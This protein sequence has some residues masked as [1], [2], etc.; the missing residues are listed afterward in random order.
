MRRFA[1]GLLL[2][3][4]ALA[5]EPIESVY[6]K[7]H[8]A[9]LAANSEAALAYA[10]AARKAEL[11][12][13]SKEEKDGFFKLMAAMMPRMYTVTGKQVAPDGRSAVLR[14]T[15]MGEFMGKQQMYAEVNFRL[16]GGSWKVDTWQWTG[17]RPTTPMAEPPR[18]AAPAKAA[19]RPVQAPSAPP[20]TKPVRRSESACVY[21]PVMT[22]EDMAKCR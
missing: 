1:L 10:T 20:T 4:V 3:L 16:E 8:A 14:A 17:D 2:P 19:Q 22:D 13:K 7:L 6:A 12:G 15:G 11:A 18:P 21:K 5:Q 9:S